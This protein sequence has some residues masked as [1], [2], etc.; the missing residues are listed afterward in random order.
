MTSEFITLRQAL[1]FWGN[2]MREEE[3]DSGKAQANISIIQDL[4]RKKYVAK[5]IIEGGKDALA[6]TE[7]QW[8]KMMDYYK[9]RS[10][11]IVTCKPNF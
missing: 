10:P 7:E 8:N 9:G 11:S 3:S 1:E 6:P 4:F 2:K 5:S